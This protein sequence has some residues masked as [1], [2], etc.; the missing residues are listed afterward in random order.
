MFEVT[1][2]AVTLPQP[3]SFLL[4]PLTT[5]EANLRLRSEGF[6][7]TVDVCARCLPVVYFLFSWSKSLL[8]MIKNPASG[9]QVLSRLP[10][11]NLQMSLAYKVVTSRYAH[12]Q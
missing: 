3:D 10:I 4:S 7:V 12:C 11:Y 8:L 5:L 6:R 1:E 2:A 9:V